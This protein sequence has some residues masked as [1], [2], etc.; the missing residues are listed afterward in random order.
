MD[1]LIGQPGE[2]GRK[3]L[4]KAGRLK[5]SRDGNLKLLLIGPPGIGKTSIVDLL[6]RE[7]GGTPWA[8]EEANGK[9]VTIETVKHWMVQLPYGCLYSD[10]SIKLVNELDRCSRDAQDLML[11]YLDKLPPGRAFMGTSNLDLN[12]LTERLQTRFQVVR[13]KAPDSE[14]IAAFL[15]RHWDA[16]EAVINMIAV[17]C[18]GNVRAA[19]AD[20]ENYFDAR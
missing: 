8:V 13:L 7:L 4:A 12:Q 2:V 9:S 3:L 11:S 15:K 1:Q 19:L 17:G 16:P 10:W 14:E 20:L 18:G 5:A 6:A